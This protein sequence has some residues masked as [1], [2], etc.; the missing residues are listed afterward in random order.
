M[1]RRPAPTPLVCPFGCAPLQSRPSVCPSDLIHTLLVPFVA[2]VSNAKRW[3]TRQAKSPRDASAASRAAAESAGGAQAGSGASTPRLTPRGALTPRVALSAGQLTP[4]PSSQWP[5][6]FPLE[7]AA[8]P[9]LSRAAARLSTITEA[10]YSKT[11]T[12]AARPRK[13][14]YAA[15]PVKRNGL[16]AALLT[17]CLL[18]G[19][20]LAVLAVLPPSVTA[21]LPGKS[22][23][24]GAIGSALLATRCCV[25]KHLKLM[26]TPV[27]FCRTWGSPRHPGRPPHRPRRA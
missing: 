26:Q 1:Q 16:L 12:H 13:P 17:L 23:A 15:A 8:A 11:A 20:S 14:G 7:G 21:Q 2:A 22:Y 6:S 4:S 25:C 27:A 18:A 9:P 3:L 10:F 24:G 5:R 19:V